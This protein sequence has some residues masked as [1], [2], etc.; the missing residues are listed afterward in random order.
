[1]TCRVRWAWKRQAGWGEQWGLL[2][3]KTPR[4]E[5]NPTPGP[6]SRHHQRGPSRASAPQPPPHKNASPPPTKKKFTRRWN[7]W[8]GGRTKMARTKSTGKEHHAAQYG[9]KMAF[10]A[11]IYPLHRTSLDADR[12]DPVAHGHGIEHRLQAEQV[13]ALVA[14]VAED[15]F[16][17]G[18]PALTCLAHHGEDVAG[19]VAARGGALLGALVVDL[20]VLREHGGGRARR[21]GEPQHSQWAQVFSTCPSRSTMD[22]RLS[23]G[24]HPCRDHGG[25]GGDALG[26][27]RG[28]R[29]QG[30][31]HLCCRGRIHVLSRWSGLTGHG[32]LIR[33][34]VV[35]IALC[36]RVG[37]GARGRHPGVTRDAMPSPLPPS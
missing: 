27:L 8:S 22:P 9:K 17:L 36:Q 12:A 37:P 30:S 21:M 32:V 28:A 15:D 1:M 24:P 16:V 25:R 29:E 31:Q 20:A 2:C 14:A 26:R 33:A 11:A 35:L 34:V 3:C 7:V 13:P 18:V 19:E 10:F 5:G 6:P 4:Q 23:P